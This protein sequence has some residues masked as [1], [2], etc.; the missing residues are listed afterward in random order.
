M[1]TFSVFLHE[2]H[3]NN[4]QK[5]SWEAGMVV[6]AISLVFGRLSQEDQELDASMGY[7]AKLCP[8]NKYLGPIARDPDSSLGSSQTFLYLKLSS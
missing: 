8:K 6:H 5:V 3:L 2:N 4:I 1:N 7:V